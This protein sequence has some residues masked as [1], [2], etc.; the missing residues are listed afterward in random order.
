M[1]LTFANLFLVDSLETALP[2]DQFDLLKQSGIQ[3]LFE[4]DSSEF[5][6]AISI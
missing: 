5:K 3:I 2:N 4:S 6:I 1:F